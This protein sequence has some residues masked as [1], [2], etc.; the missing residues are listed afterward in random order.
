MS[1]RIEIADPAGDEVRAAECRVLDRTRELT[2]EDYAN[3]VTVRGEKQDDG[4]RLKASARSP[5]GVDRF[6][7]QFLNR[8]RKRLP[9]GR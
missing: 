6:G 8:V 1:H 9:S 3:V 2:G 4:S 7:E 5:S